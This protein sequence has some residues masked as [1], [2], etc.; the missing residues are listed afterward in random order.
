LHDHGS[1]DVTVNRRAALV[2]A[3]GDDHLD[4]VGHGRGRRAVARLRRPAGWVEARRAGRPGGGLAVPI[5]LD[6]TV[7]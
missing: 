4:E 7:P 5:R 3:R 1:G 6:G 2:G